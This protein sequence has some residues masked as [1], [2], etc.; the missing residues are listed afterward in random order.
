M[1][2]TH[3]ILYVVFGAIDVMKCEAMR[4]VITDAGRRQSREITIS[5]LVFMA[6]THQSAVFR[7]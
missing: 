6:A 4:K 1:D 2:K 7:Y 5:G 3:I